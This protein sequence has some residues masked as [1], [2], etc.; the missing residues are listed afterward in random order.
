MNTASTLTH[1]ECSMTG[2]R[3]DADR[4]WNLSPAA[5]R[6]LL[7]RYD[8]PTAAHTLTREALAHRPHNLWRYEEV[9]PVR[10]REHIIC[11]NEG[12]TPLVEAKRLGKQIG[13]ANT[14]IKDESPN[15]T[16]SFKARGQAVAISRALELGVKELAIPSAGNA[17]GAMSAYAAAAGLPAHVFMPADVPLAFRA[18]CH[19]FGAHVTLVDGLINVCG[20]KVRE[21][22]AA[23]G[24]F[25]VST[26]KEPYR[27][28]GKKTMGYELAEQMQWG[29]PDV[30]IYPAGGGTGLIGLWKAFDEM[31]TMG[32]L[33]AGTKRPRLVCVQSDGC[34]PIV[35]A[36]HDGVE[37][38]PLWEGAKTI[39]DGLRVPVAVGDFL[40]IRALKASGGTAVMVSDETMM[41][42]ANLIART[43]GI[44]AA[45]EG[46]ACLAA[47]VHLLAEGW[48]R[49]DE[50]VVLFNTGT[51]LKYAHLWA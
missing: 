13:C 29:L 21:G 40:M 7:A 45:P 16:G 20:A 46:G 5:E 50:T 39:A 36:F 1:L 42:H 9:L 47:Q 4:I 51:G 6:P 10:Q 14:F 23:H 34:A 44:F 12:W 38:A 24:W 31:E 43:T 27:L 15:P 35:K 26:L 22:V 28:E 41:T 25:D 49:P 11:L 2:E 37:H 8:L 18:E 17:A 19:A 33:P 3:Y 30:I 48:I 32:L